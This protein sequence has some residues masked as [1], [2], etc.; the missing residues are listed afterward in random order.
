MAILKVELKVAHGRSESG[1]LKAPTGPEYLRHIATEVRSSAGYCAWGPQ[2][3][4]LLKDWYGQACKV[5]SA[6]GFE[7]M[8][9]WTLCCTTHSF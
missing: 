7:D 2:E 4:E 9:C 8:H 3:M 1:C 5:G 6:S